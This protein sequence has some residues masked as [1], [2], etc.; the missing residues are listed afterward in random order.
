MR[1]NKKQKR[2]T[3]KSQSDL[4][5]ILSI[6]LALTAIGGIGYIIYDIFQPQINKSIEKNFSIQISQ[7]TQTNHILEE[8]IT[9]ELTNIT[10]E[11]TQSP[12][13]K[14]SEKQQPTYT[15]TN[16]KLELKKN[17]KKSIPENIFLHY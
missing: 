17:L 10:I 4:T 6:I 12:K 15:K 8:E 5:K 2:K 16:Q 13:D 14:L 11:E 3:K 1:K 9:R 7:F